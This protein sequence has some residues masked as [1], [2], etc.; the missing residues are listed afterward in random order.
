MPVLAGVDEAHRTLRGDPGAGRAA[1]LAGKTA[2]LEDVGEVGGEG[3][4]EVQFEGLDAEVAQRQAF[5]DAPLPDE[6]RAGDV[7][8][9]ARKDEGVAHE[10]VG[11]GEVRRERRVVQ[12]QV[13]AE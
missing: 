8:D 3:E 11:V 1:G 5:V 6:A 10:D 9:V 13:G 12:Q 7:D 4:V 2:R